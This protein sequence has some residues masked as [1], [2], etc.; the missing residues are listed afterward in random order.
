[1]RQAVE[2]HQRGSVHLHVREKREERG[3]NHQQLLIHFVLREQLFHRSRDH[4][5]TGGDEAD[6]H[7]DQPHKAA[8]GEE[9]PRHETEGRHRQ[10]SPCVEVDPQEGRRFRVLLLKL[11]GVDFLV[12]HQCHL[13]IHTYFVELL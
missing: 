12:S 13:R 4:T 8:R 7:E 2:K 11:D 9:Q 3:G 5:V 1:M 6:K 10:G